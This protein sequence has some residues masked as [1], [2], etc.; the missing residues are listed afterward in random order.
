MIYK[1]GVIYLIIFNLFSF[2]CISAQNSKNLFVLHTQ[3]TPMESLEINM[4]D[5]KLVI[6]KILQD[7]FFFNHIKNDSVLLVNIIKNN[8]NGNIQTNK[9]TSLL[10]NCIL[11]NTR[12]YKVICIEQLYVAYREL[13][14][15]PE[16]HMNSYSFS[17]NIANYLQANYVLYGVIYGDVTHPILE[18][19][20][21]LVK[22][23]EILC[24]INQAV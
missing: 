2:Y 1:K 7:A 19:Q 18:L 16:D 20:L 6:F 12:K 15:F 13:G 22:T 4:I 14:V 24:V 23:G 3:P 9:I 5:W 11:E 8:T 10:I 17:I 21:I